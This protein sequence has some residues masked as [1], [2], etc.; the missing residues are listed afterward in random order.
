MSS[1]LILRV[2]NDSS[3]QEVSFERSRLIK[4]KEENFKL[5]QMM[6]FG[7][8]LRTLCYGVKRWFMLALPQKQQV[9]VALHYMNE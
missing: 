4:L 1:T 2:T 7:F 5:W 6:Q 9:A 3:V 8:S